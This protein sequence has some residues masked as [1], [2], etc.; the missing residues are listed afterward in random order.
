MPGAQEVAARFIEAFNAHDEG[1]IRELSAENE[2]FEAPGD[3]KVEGRDAAT[4]TP[5]RG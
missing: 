1:A 2:V 5:C 3:V 4:A